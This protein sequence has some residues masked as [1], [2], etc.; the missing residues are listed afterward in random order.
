M[1]SKPITPESGHA[2]AS[3]DG[4]TLADTTNWLKCEG[5]VYFPPDSLVRGDNGSAAPVFSNTDRMTYCPW[6]GHAGYY[7][8][9]VAGTKVE[10]AAW[11]Y[12]DP[13]D[14]AISIKNYVAFDKSK[15]KIHVE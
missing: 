11:Y 13:F 4:H 14:K 10:N 1:S 6:K 3:L 5:N 8:V 9:D 12:D 7:T 2:T 15:V